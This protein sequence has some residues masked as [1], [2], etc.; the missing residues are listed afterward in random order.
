MEAPGW[1]LAIQ[2]YQVRGPRQTNISRSP[3]GLCC[4]IRAKAPSGSEE[5]VLSRTV[6]CH[7]PKAPFANCW[8]PKARFLGFS[9]VGRL[10][11]CA[12]LLRRGLDVVL[13]RVRRLVGPTAP[14]HVG[15]KSGTSK[16]EFRQ[17]GL[18]CH[19]SRLH[20][21]HIRGT[22]VEGQKLQQTRIAVVELVNFTIQYGDPLE[23]EDR[24]KRP[25]ESASMDNEAR[26]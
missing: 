21:R 9:K 11:A 24:S 5:F 6:M 26:I 8:L 13:L 20:T 17:T 7:L 18:L 16:A 10:S 14:N 15:E 2:S 3:F 1:A 4:Q 12:V 19:A 23:I 25:R 22:A